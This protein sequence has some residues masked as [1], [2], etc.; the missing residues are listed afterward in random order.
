MKVLPLPCGFFFIIVIQEKIYCIDSQYGQLHAV[1][2][3]LQ[4][5]KLYLENL[6]TFRPSGFWTF[7]QFAEDF[8]T[9][10]K[11]SKYFPTIFEHFKS[12]FKCDNFSM[13]C[14]DTVTTLQVKIFV[15][16]PSGNQLFGFSHQGKFL[17]TKLY[18]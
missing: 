12:Y 1:V 11:M 17:A 13:A 18:Q 8:W 9:L 6:V 4:T 16:W 10:P 15:Q 14:C 7:W 3:W 2:T 5:K